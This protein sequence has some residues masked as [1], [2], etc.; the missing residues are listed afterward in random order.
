MERYD[1]QIRI[2]GAKAQEVLEDA[3]VAIFAKNYGEPLVQEVVKNLG[4]AN[5]GSI[6]L[7]L[8]EVHDEGLTENNGFFLSISSMLM[9]I[10]TDV[11]VTDWNTFVNKGLPVSIVVTLNLED[12]KDIQYI[13]QLRREPLISANVKNE[14]GIV[15]LIKLPEPHIIMDT[16]PDYL[17][18]YLWIDRPWPELKRFYESFD[19]SQLA[20][21]GQLS[22]VPYPVILYHIVKDRPDGDTWDSND[23]KQKIDE[24]F[25]N[26]RDY[27]NVIEARRFAHLALR[28]AENDCRQLHEML[29]CVCSEMVGKTKWFDLYNHTLAILCLCLKQLLFS[30]SF[31]LPSAK[32]LP[33]MESSTDIYSRFRS[34]Y[35]AKEDED[36]ET[37]SKLLRTRPESEDISDSTAREFLSSL[38]RLGVLSCKKYNGEYRIP[39]PK[40]PINSPIVVNL[41]KV[42]E[43]PTAC[44]YFHA[45]CFIGGLVSQEIIKLITHQHVPIDD[46]YTYSPDQLR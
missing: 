7:V 13:S 24:K 36:V 41:A 10:S 42:S 4:L 29:D 2:W 28:T 31:C 8:K 43:R 30:S 34:I 9:G 44:N 38:R 23:V 32:D 6:I 3:K 25:P 21:N 15:Q 45:S 46:V 14:D 27:L 26:Q 19:M 17:V 37:F 35:Q 40:G 12:P 33:D 22:K 39:D 11:E 20:E 16:H 5:V 1:R 18:P